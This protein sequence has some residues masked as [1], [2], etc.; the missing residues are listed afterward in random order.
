VKI[1]ALG[2]SMLTQALIAAVGY[3][4]KFVRAM[5]VRSP[6][7]YAPRSDAIQGGLQ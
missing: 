2:A 3:A 7:K 4:L 1:E 6:S 5:D